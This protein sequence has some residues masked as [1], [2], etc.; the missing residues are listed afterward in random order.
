MSGV[1]QSFFLHAIERNQIW[2]I[3]L[4]MLLI[5]AVYFATI[6]GMTFLLGHNG[7]DLYEIMMSRSPQGLAVMLLSFFPVWVG[8]AIVNR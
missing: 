6:F 4:G 3:L 2:R 8:V 1:Q 5:V 7:I